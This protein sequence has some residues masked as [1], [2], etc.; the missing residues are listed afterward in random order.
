VPIQQNIT[1]RRP[2]ATGETEMME[3]RQV[4]EVETRVIRGL[5]NH[6]WLWKLFEKVED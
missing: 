6:G 4:D 1:S 3:G 2:T 5:K